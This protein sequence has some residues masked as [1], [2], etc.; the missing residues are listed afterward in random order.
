MSVQEEKWWFDVGT[1]GKE[2]EVAEFID[3]CL[4]LD[5]PRIDFQPQGLQ[6]IQ[7]E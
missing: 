3:A 2:G 6:D 5:L 1:R 7:I 4:Q